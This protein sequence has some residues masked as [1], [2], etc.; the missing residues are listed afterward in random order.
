MAA[1]ASPK[2]LQ[3]FSKTSYGWLDKGWS[4]R[5]TFSGL[6]K[7]PKAVWTE[8]SKVGNLMLA[9]AGRPSIPSA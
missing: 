9:E 7:P 4:C 3:R 5:L 6:S 1:E 2:I 8:R